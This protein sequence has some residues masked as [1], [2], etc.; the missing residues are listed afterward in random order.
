MN[1]RVV[2][3]DLLNLGMGL[4]V[5][6][7]HQDFVKFIVLGRGRSGSNFLS[8]S[9]AAHQNVVTFG[10]VFNN[11]AQAKGTIHFAYPG[12]RNA[13]PKL[14]DQRDNRPVEFVDRTLFGQQPKSIYA[15]GFKLFYYHAQTPQWRGVWPHLKNQGVRAVHI[16]RTNLLASLVSEQIAESTKV[17]QTNK[18]VSVGTQTQPSVRIAPAVCAEYFTTVRR[19]HEEFSEFF[20]STLDI[21]YEDLVEDYQGQLQ[22]VQEFLSLPV[23]TLASPLKKQAKRPLPAMLENFDE[24]AAHFQNTAW[25]RYFDDAARDS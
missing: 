9:L 22:R 8:T 19:L 6:P 1:R 21:V 12:Y 25:Q 3:R 5:V 15:V 13:Q 11:R 10:E 20:D 7:S 2:K 23:Q 18:D 4:G 24:L 14:V 16:R 17:W